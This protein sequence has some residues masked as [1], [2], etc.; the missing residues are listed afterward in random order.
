MSTSVAAEPR[1]STATGAA[2]PSMADSAF[3]DSQVRQMLMDCRDWPR[4]IGWEGLITKWAD[5]LYAGNI[6]YTQVMT[7][8]AQ[9]AWL[10]QHHLGSDEAHPK[11]PV[12][13]LVLMTLRRF[14]TADVRYLKGD[15]DAEQ[16]EFWLEAAI[17]D[18]ACWAVGIENSAD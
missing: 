13:D 2:R 10:R 3:V 17:E 5:V 16:H 4:S 6:A 9:A 1:R 18:C 12:T 14:V 11:A 7:P 15:I 8:E